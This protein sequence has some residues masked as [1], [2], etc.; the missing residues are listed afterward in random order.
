M[1][2]F[3]R[4]GSENFAEEG[5]CIGES[6]DPVNRG[7]HIDFT[8]YEEG[9]EEDREERRRGKESGEKDLWTAAKHSQLWRWQVS[10]RV[11]AALQPPEVR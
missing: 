10:A 1:P 3:F 9:K 6:K 4:E 2:Q 11:N 7:A 5:K 8:L